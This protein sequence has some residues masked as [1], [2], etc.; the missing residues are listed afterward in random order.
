VSLDH[1]HLLS[2]VPTDLGPEAF[3]FVLAYT[4]IPAG[5]G[6]AELAI[7]L[8]FRLLAFSDMSG[9]SG[10]VKV[11]RREALLHRDLHLVPSPRLV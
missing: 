11:L 8:K 3:A 9:E 6:P 7:K 2:Y 5:I 10:L 1:R 4:D